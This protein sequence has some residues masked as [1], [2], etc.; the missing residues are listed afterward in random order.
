MTRQQEPVVTKQ[1]L[2][3]LDLGRLKAQTHGSLGLVP[4]R[5]SNK[6]A[7]KSSQRGAYSDTRG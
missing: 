7:P 2:T 6:P 1:A 4:E 3:S 5:D